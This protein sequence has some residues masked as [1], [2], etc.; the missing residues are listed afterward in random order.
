M[1]Q[2]LWRLGTLDLAG[3]I[4]AKEVSS[5]EVIDAHLARIEAVNPT[6]NAVTVTLVDEA[7]AAA[8][9]GIACS[10]QRVC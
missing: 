3:R 9:A 8:A 5:R 7:M 10:L 6:V 4:A 1:T 2:K